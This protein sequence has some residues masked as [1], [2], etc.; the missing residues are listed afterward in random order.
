MPFFDHVSG[1]YPILVLG[2]TAKNQPSIIPQ[3]TP[4]NPIMKAVRC[5]VLFDQALSLRL[6]L[7]GSVAVAI[8]Q[9][10][11]DHLRRA[12]ICSAMS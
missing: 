10:P 3:P 1:L 12:L 11:V 6:L 2:L 5:R 4:G 8:L 7:V 9:R